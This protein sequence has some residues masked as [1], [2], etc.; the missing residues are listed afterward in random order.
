MKKLLLASLAAIFFIFSSI[1]VAQEL[2]IG[3]VS[4]SDVMQK[5][6]QR[7]QVVAKLKQEF[8]RRNQELIKLKKDLEGLQN[9]LDK[10][11]AV[12]TSNEAQEIQK[13]VIEKRR[14]LRN[15]EEAFQEDATRREQEEAQKLLEKIGKIVDDL[16][17]QEKYDLIIRR[18]AAPF[19]VSERVE[20]TQKVL[21]KLQEQATSAK[22]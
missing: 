8:D 17:K 16:A 20:V 12:I 9:K 4:V 5:Y 15:L 2:K 11:A 13:K 6:P 10:D 7:E 19:Y 1:S 21:N 18:E 3:V 22:K 14:T